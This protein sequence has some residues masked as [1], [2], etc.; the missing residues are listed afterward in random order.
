MQLE[1]PDFESGHVLI[2]GDLM[3]DR[4]WYGDTKRISPEAPVPVVGIGDTEDRPGG[5]ANVA[6]N[7]VALEG[8]AR[9]IG[10]S[11]DDAD[12][13]RLA[14][15]LAS[16]GVPCDLT[17]VNGHPTICKLRVMSRRSQLLRMDFEA[18][19]APEDAAR[20]LAPFQAAVREANV[21]IL[22]D[23]AKG[24]LAD[25]PALI[26][27]AQQAGVPVL[28]DPKG[29]DFSRYRGAD[30]VTPNLAEFEAVV[31]HCP[32][33]ATLEAQARALMSEC[34][35]G[36]LLITRGADGMTLV[37]TGDAVVHMPA[38]AREVYDVTGAGDTVIAVLAAAMAGG[39]SLADATGLAN[40]AAGLVVAKSGTATVT[41][42]A[43]RHAIDGLRGTDHGPVTEATLKARLND[44]RARG[45][46]VVMTNG[47]FDLLHAGHV[48]YLQQAR[49]LGDRLVVAVNTDESVARLKG[50]ERPLMPL[51]ERMTVLASLAAVDDVVAFSE[52]TPARL[53]EAMSPDVL[54]KGG[55]YAPD[56]IAGADAVRARGGEVVVLDFVDG[57][58]TS[59]L[60]DRIRGGHH[61]G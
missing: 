54:V 10:L 11:G 56:S 57:L 24:A 30:V 18:P 9:V 8:R 26:H 61:S 27:E 39:A 15:T 43:L 13:D 36:A 47:C 50:P 55:D 28:V 41:P 48:T 16:Q 45:E 31:G 7:V 52:D 19:F 53:I 3:V 40:V 6:L 58:S 60:I 17:R 4:Y 59:G 44:A 51:A 37:P 21:V 35:L 14:Q 12:A 38:H 20:L 29:T 49:A 33:S 5:A 25:A 2:A 46:R 1:W 23:Y 42:S 34:G 32:D 22:S